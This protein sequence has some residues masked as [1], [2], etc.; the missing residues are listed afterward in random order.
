MDI[1]GRQASASDEPSLNPLLLANN[2]T[3][4]ITSSETRVYASRWWMLLVFSLST[5]MSAILW[6]TFAPIA[7]LTQ[8]YYN[9]DSTYVNGLSIVF[10]VA[11]VPFTV[12]SSWVFRRYGVRRGFFLASAL[13]MLSGLLRFASTSNRSYAVL[14]LGQTTG[15]M[16]QPFFTNMPARLAAIWFPTPERDLAVVLGFLANIF[17]TAVGSV[18]PAAFTSRT[19]AG[20]DSIHMRELLLVEFLLTLLIVVVVAHFFQ[21]KPPTPPSLSESNRIENENATHD[22]KE[23]LKQLFRNQDFVIL[24]VSTGCLSLG[25][26]NSLVTVLEQIIA[27]AGYSSDDASLFSGLCIVSG[28]L[29]SIV[30]G[31]IMDKTHAYNP[32]LK[33]GLVLGA[34][35]SSLFFVALRPGQVGLLAAICCLIGMTMLPLLPLAMECA[36]ECTYPISEDLS[37]GVLL[38]AGQVSGIFILF[39]LN[40]V[41]E[42]E[43]SY[44]SYQMQPSY[45]IFIGGALASAVIGSL[46]QGK[47]LRLE[48][49]RDNHTENQVSVAEAPFVSATESSAPAVPDAESPAV[50]AAVDRQPPPPQID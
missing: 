7:N 8:S 39:V 13:N 23:Q 16:A 27:P 43:T 24:V 29:F 10:M 50:S 5:A 3:S 12:I 31:A 17:G 2:D 40:S 37:S 18:L 28:I 32:M 35:A 48:A 6:I 22:V 46:Y 14:F 9:V 1:G 15:A 36:C 49:D 26:L 21:E 4:S 34:V 11:Y 42:K 47:Y 44:D 25:L 33:I 19:A 30:V 20:V 38:S 45:L 41:L